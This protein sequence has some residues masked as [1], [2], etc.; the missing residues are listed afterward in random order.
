MLRTEPQHDVQERQDESAGSF[1]KEAQVFQENVQ[2]IECKWLLQSAN[3]RGGG[4]AG[5]SV[6]GE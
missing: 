2:M 6:P 5:A 4:G 3:V 1:R